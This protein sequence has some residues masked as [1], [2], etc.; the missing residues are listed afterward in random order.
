MKIDKKTAIKAVVILF[1]LFLCIHYWQIVEN[2]V[3]TLTGTLTPV[4]SGFFIAYVLNIIMS[5][6]E[7]HYFKKAKTNSFLAKTRRPVCLVLAILTL[8]AIL[9]FVVIMVIPEL[10][11]CIKILI[12]QIPPAMEKLINNKFVKEIL[13]ANALSMLVAIDWREHIGNIADMLTS[14]IG[15]AA[16]AIF[17]AITSVFTVAATVLLSIIFA[18]YMLLSKEKLSHHISKVSQRYIA[19]KP[20]LKITHII[21]VSDD[22]FKRYIVGQCTEA[23]ILGVLCIIG[24]YILRLPYAP[25][26]GTLIGLTALIPIAGAYI[27]AAVGAI[28][29]L[30]VAP[31]KAFVFLIFIVVLQQFEGNIIYPKVVGNKLGLPAIYVLLAITIGGGLWGI[32]GMLIGVPIMS[33]IYRLVKE[34]VYKN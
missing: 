28:M 8:C 21:K 11:A 16:T 18:V 2:G 20:R 33:V 14:G 7:R 25:M 26:I 13:P 10:V 1:I 22:S 34:D 6:Y 19:E 29:I 12:A 23:V 31:I 24:M 30:T 17:S 32:F 3:Y 5:F 9:S 27:G 4:I 15:N